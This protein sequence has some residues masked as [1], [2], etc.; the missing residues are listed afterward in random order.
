MP[1]SGNALADAAPRARSGAFLVRQIVRLVVW[2]VALVGGI[3]AA[4]LLAASTASADDG[5]L[6]GGLGHAVDNG[7]GQ[8]VGETVKQVEAVAPK[9]V[10]PKPV[11]PEPVAPKPVAP[12]P[13][14]VHLQQVTEKVT[15]KVAK[16]VAPV[17]KVTKNLQP[18][19]GI[20]AVDD[21]VRGATE[22]V[23]HTVVAPVVK[24]VASTVSH[25][26][27]AVRETVAPVTESVTHA[28]TQV[29]SQVSP[30]TVLPPAA[31]LPPAPQ[32]RT[33]EPV[34]APAVDHHPVG[35]AAAA[36]PVAT[37][38]LGAAPAPGAT[39]AT[40]SHHRVGSAFV[41][42]S[43]ETPTDFPQLPTAPAQGPVAQTGS[44]QSA[45]ELAV[46][47]AVLRDGSHGL[48][49]LGAGD[50]GAPLSRAAVVDTRPA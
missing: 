3:L 7:L 9:P 5:S 28:A 13:Q 1:I 6:T 20:P 8:G 42:L 17:A 48:T 32:V 35:S 33:V 19:Q 24:H 2:S 37:D 4:L 36:Q 45:G 46:L 21:V 30:A 15:E 25:T 49:R 40:S 18:T 10:A 41:G 43:H 34:K 27:G 39:A 26:V 11:A 16:A 47:D 14:P 31:V 38:L 22:T 12:K 44:G 50:D 23:E 29:V